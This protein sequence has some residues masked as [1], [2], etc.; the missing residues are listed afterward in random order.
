MSSS[1]FL[2]RGK[3][4]ALF[5]GAGILLALS[6]WMMFWNLGASSISIAS[7]EVIYVRI[8][9]GILHEGKIFP[10][11]HGKLPSFEKPP[12][13]FW[14]NA[15]IPWF[16]GE[17]NW[18]FRSLSAGLGVCSVI[19]TV[20]L[21][22]R[23]FG[24][25]IGA[26][27]V[28]F[29][30]LGVPEW[31]IA[32]HGFRRV[33]L[34]CLLTGMT[35]GMA[36]FSW[37][38]I[39]DNR[40]GRSATSN[41]WGVVALCSLALMTKSVAAFVPLVCSIV[42][43]IA[44]CPRFL[45]VRRGLIVLIP[46]V[47]FSAYIIALW[48]VGGFK[49]IE[50]FLGTEILTRTFGGF[51]GHNTNDP[52]FYWRYLFVRGAGAPRA[53]LIMGTLG[54][55]IGALKDIRLR[56]LAVWGF[57]PVIAY[58]CAASKTPWYLNPF[59]PFL[60]MVAVFGTAHLIQE[61]RRASSNRALQGIVVCVV[62]AMTLPAYERA[63]S[64]HMQEV[65]HDTSRLEIDLLVSQL[66]ERFSSFLIV[67]GCISGHSNPRR[68]RFNVEGIYREMLKPSLVAV[69]DPAQVVPIL[70]QVVFLKEEALGALPTGWQELGRARPYGFRS[71]TVVA[72]EY[73]TVTK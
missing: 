70:G 41:L 54:V 2:Q 14:M 3:L 10:L 64:R 15:I 72:V 35:L 25:M 63:V 68:G 19:I 5:I 47:V 28:G 8:V 60:C 58:S 24:S 43:I 34:D 37:R 13:F 59:F 27:A 20:A 71:W 36:L 56:Y 12:L 29:L 51:E 18:S 45:S 62:L 30:L 66:R 32:Q 7:D 57:V 53:L 52:F 69:Q 46:G 67:D 50:I 49:A 42:S 11:V 73:P 21:A 4:T 9:Q 33:V 61:L 26:L 31:I 23:V 17:S 65:A 44:I 55:V 40:S 39:E 1:R 22:R 16:V 38:V 6:I 48:V